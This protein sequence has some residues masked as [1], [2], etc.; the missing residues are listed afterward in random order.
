MIITV[1]LNKNQQPTEEQIR[2]IEKASKREI[3]FDEDSP[4]L[5]PAMERE[6]RQAAK[7]RNTHKKTSIL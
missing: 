2:R 7:N 3:L 6:F 5:T 4:A 1:T